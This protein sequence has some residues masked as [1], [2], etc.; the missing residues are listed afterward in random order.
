MTQTE[1]AIVLGVVVYV[2]SFIAGVCLAL[3][4]QREV[5]E[6]EL[7]KRIALVRSQIQHANTSIDNY[8]ATQASSKN[9]NN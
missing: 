1:F 6:Q 5:L 2:V 9:C 7:E 8:E 4:F 3:K